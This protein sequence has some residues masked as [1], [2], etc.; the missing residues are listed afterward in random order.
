MKRSRGWWLSGGLG[1][2]CVPGLLFF[3]FSTQ[4]GVSGVLLPSV[5][6]VATPGDAAPHL[7]RFEQEEALRE[8]RNPPARCGKPVEL[9][10]GSR[11]AVLH[12]EDG[13]I[14]TGNEFCKQEFTSEGVRLSGERGQLALS[15]R[16][17]R[18]GGRSLRSG[19]L[20]SD[21]KPGLEPGAPEHVVYRRGSV[22][23]KYM[24][25][26]EGVEQIF[27]LDSHLALLQREGDLTVTVA[28]D[29]PLERVQNRRSAGAREDSLEFRDADGTSVLTYGGATAIDARGHRRS[30]TYEV[31]GNELAMVLDAEF[32]ASA[33]FPLTIDPTIQLTPATMIFSAPLGGPNPAP[34]RAQLKNIGTGKLH[35][36][37]TVNAPWLILAPAQ[38][39][40]QAGM[41][42]NI[43]VSVDVTGLAA[44]V[45]T[46]TITVTGNTGPQPPQTIAVTLYVNS[47]PTIL[48]DPTSLT[49]DSPDFG[50]NPV[51]QT[52]TLQNVG[53]GTLTWNAAANVTT[54]PAGTWLVVS[55]LT[56][57]LSPGAT[58]TLTVSVNHGVLSGGTYTGTI[59]VSNDSVPPEVPAQP[60]QIVGVTLNVNSTPK[61]LLS[62]AAGL[63]FDIPST[64]GTGTASLPMTVTNGG[65]GTLTWTAAPGVV[66][67]GGGTWLG[68]GPTTGSLGPGAS[69]T[70]SVNVTRGA[71]SAGSYDGLI[72]VTAGGAS[73]SPQ[74]VPIVLNVNDQPTINLTPSNLTFTAAENG[75]VPV[76]Q[77][78]TLGNTGI[79]TL[80]WTATKL[81]GATWLTVVPP[82]GTVVAGAT[83]PLTVSVNQT[84][85][86]AGTYTDEI[87]VSDPAATNPS[88]LVFVTLNVVT[89]PTIGLSP[90]S[91]S[92]SAPE[93]GTPPV[94]QPLTV[95]NT[96]S[97]TLNWAATP[98]D[99]W[100][101]VL[102]AGGSLTAGASATPSVSVNQT[103]L[104]AGTYNGSILI[105]APGASNT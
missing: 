78:V 13:L 43:N 94:S 40:R 56:V 16:D 91:F 101:A 95:R 48:L 1:L 105:D 72:S 29:S 102:P 19:G 9:R 65:G 61:I 90:L 5:V 85:L 93:N 33:R 77:T 92:F 31:R 6:P 67:P 79:G 60:N 4:R 32:L 97:G 39:A 99:S 80:T 55:P 88:E 83:T 45:Y 36:T 37:A 82:S 57:N 98:S 81:G 21:G 50:P 59:S 46:A 70:L 104:V 64:G 66:T 87:E 54:P 34:K 12:S 52:V 25:V 74:S 62:P 96:G 23:E 30:L 11:S 18:I 26:N 27:V 84:G 76:S 63:T 51:P 14:R 38:G 75:S 3:A 47:G 49:F 35:W 69:A 58:A 7:S 2:A 89:N 10:M 53:P 20:L 22:T 15:L 41:T 73:N 100:L 103:G 17:I 28:L 8:A 42:K 86:V 44:G 68:V 71:L 24:L